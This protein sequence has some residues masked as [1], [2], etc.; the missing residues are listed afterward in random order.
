MSNIFE[1]AVEF[2]LKAHEGQRRK[3]GGVY[4]L[5]PLEDATIVATMT[6]DEEVLAAAVLHDTVEDTDV[7]MEDILT[8]FGER[9][10]TLVAHET[11]DK[12]EHLDPSETWKIRKVESLEVLRTCNDRDTKIL[13]LGDKLSNMRSLAKDYLLIGEEV[14]EGLTRKIRENSVGTM[15]QCCLI[16]PNSKKIP[17]IRSTNFFLILFLTSTRTTTDTVTGVY[18]WKKLLN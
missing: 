1:Q 18:L 14:F 13:W 5:H 10:A 3:D 9:V 11:E 16:L 2:A 6:Q 17:L 7:T 12:R 4:I 15:K 8:N